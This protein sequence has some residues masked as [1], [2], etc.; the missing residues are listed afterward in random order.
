MEFPGSWV[1]TPQDFHCSGVT[2]CSA[3]LG[4]EI[5]YFPFACGLGSLPLAGTPVSCKWWRYPSMPA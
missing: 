4:N 2:G 1:K 5:I 3:D